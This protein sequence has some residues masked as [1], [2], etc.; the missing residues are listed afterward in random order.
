M[1]QTKRFIA[2]ASV[3]VDER[4]RR[5]LSLSGK[6]VTSNDLSHV[7]TGFAPDHPR[8]HR[9]YNFVIGLLL[10]LTALPLLAFLMLAVFATQG[11]KV[12]Y[13]GK[14]VGKDGHLYD[15]IKFRTLDERRAREMTA[16]CV[17]PAG[18][19][20]ETPLGSFLRE[21]RLDE[22]PQLLNVVLGD[23]NI[24][25]PR[26]VRP[27][28]AV[29][30]RLE[31]NNYD[32]RFAVRPGL[33]GHTQAY[34]HHGTSKALRARYNNVLCRAPVRYRGELGMV[35]LV[36]A[37]VI[38]RTLTKLWEKV[39]E[40]LLGRDDAYRERAVA[41]A[42]RLAFVSS[43]GASYTV[44]RV[45]HA[46][47]TF[48]GRARVGEMAEGDIVISLPNGA[49]RRARVVL[50]ALS[51]GTYFYEAETDYGH[52]IVSRYLWQ[53]IV[54]PHHSHFWPVAVWRWMRRGGQASR[55]QPN[56]AILRSEIEIGR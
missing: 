52:H 20:I 23:M 4:R 6:P 48:A 56:E 5:R 10:L 55:S 54:V 26:P 53:A 3:P 29:I 47:L 45:G 42:F 13:R 21:T 7:S 41:K 46:E 34:M 36:G 40:M 22:L 28:M 11:W 16:D 12:F 17:L 25:G 39:A 8:L 27:E 1:F 38:A 9:I 44:E 19:G 14:R 15:I 43:C 24:C 37:C 35:A 18:S 31:I 32:M 51:D 30:Q 49:A 2:F 33:I 50:S